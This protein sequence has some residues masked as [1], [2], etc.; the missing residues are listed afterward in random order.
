MYFILFLLLYLFKSDYKNQFINLNDLA[1]SIL[2]LNDNKLFKI[3][4]GSSSKSK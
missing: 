3:Y 4:D 1:I 2:W